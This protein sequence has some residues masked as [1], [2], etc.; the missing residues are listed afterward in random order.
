MKWPNRSERSNSQIL[1]SLSIKVIV[2]VLSIVGASISIILPI[3]K[4]FLSE[5]LT[6]FERQFKDVKRVM[7]MKIVRVMVLYISLKFTDLVSLRRILHLF[8]T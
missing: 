5:T 4:S 7:H 6:S 8:S 1:S 2:F 3:I